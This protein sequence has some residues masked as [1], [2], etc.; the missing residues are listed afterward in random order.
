MFCNIF[1]NLSVGKKKFHLS[2]SVNNPKKMNKMNRQ[3]SNVQQI[4]K[5]QIL[6]SHM[7]QTIFF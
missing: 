2:M 7:Y 3:F 1:H 5:I 6:F 4:T